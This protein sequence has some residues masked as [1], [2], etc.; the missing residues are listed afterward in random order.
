MPAHQ[1]VELRS[2]VV[3]AEAKSWSSPQMWPKLSSFGASLSLLLLPVA[4]A[5]GEPDAGSHM[6]SSFS[7]PG[8]INKTRS[9]L[10]ISASQV[11]LGRTSIN[12]L[13]G[14]Q[15]E[16]NHSATAAAAASTQTLFGVKFAVNF[17]N[18]SSF[19]DDDPPPRCPAG[20]PDA[21]CGCLG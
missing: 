4:M 21:R 19:I 17:P 13:R 5:T 11:C 20:P 1:R 12:A 10:C 14:P 3:S 8:P 7:L 6:S 9:T 16:F 15:R 2:V 18:K